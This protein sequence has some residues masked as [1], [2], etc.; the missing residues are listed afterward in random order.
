M[1]YCHLECLLL[2][3]EIKK[4]VEEY[5]AADGEKKLFMEK[6]Y[7]TKVLRSAMEEFE[8]EK[9]LDSNAK[10]CPG[11]GARIEVSHA[12]VSLS[13]TAIV[14][15]ACRWCQAIKRSVNCSFMLDA[16]VDPGWGV[17]GC[18]SPSQITTALR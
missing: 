1:F 13:Q 16:V 15:W 9:W 5:N 3:G 11:C 17:V 14:Q 4:L 6:K 12:G 8:S 2:L 10:S 18:G 7:G